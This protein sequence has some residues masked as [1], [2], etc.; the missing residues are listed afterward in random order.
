MK[1]IYCS[2]LAAVLVAALG[3][4]TGCDNVDPNKGYTTRSPH[5]SNIKTV[6]LEMFHNQT[7]RREIEFELSRALGIQ[8]ETH[9]PFKLVSD[10]LT[11]DT[12]LSGT[13]TSVS[14]SVMTQ[15][16]DLGRPMENQIIMVAEVTWKDQ[17]SAELILNRQQVKTTGEYSYLAG[18]GRRS[19]AWQAAD[20]MAVRIVEMMEAPW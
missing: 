17:R 19:A 8:I 10:R 13:I 1:R 12:V 6:Y 3:A 11:A 18:A 7:F 5:H 9:T 16:R 4:S 2:L 20:E 15:Q 14:E